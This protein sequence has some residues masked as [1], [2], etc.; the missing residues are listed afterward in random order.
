VVYKQLI[1]FLQDDQQGIRLGRA[2]IVLK[3]TKESTNIVDELKRFYDI[4]QRICI[5]RLF[6]QELK[7]VNHSIE[8]K[9]QL[10][11]TDNL[12]HKITVDNKG[13]VCMR[14]G[15]PTYYYSKRDRPSQCRECGK[16][17]K[18]RKVLPLPAEKP[19]IIIHVKNN[20]KRRTQLTTE[21][22]E[23]LNV[24]VTLNH[25]IAL[26]QTPIRQVIITKTLEKHVM[27]NTT[28]VVVDGQ[29][30][31]DGLSKYELFDFVENPLCLQ[32]DPFQFNHSDP[33]MFD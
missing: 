20:S 30:V 29:T 32:C 24:L 10:D 4:S 18:L 9:A 25:A 22:A 12:N 17:G 1:L 14:S 33:E 16:P 5:L 19:T 11:K 6:P 13:S 23:S 31:Y 3:T 26:R 2:V 27:S 7:T 28:K 8:I 21:L 15:F